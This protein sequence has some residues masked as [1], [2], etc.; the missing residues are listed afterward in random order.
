MQVLVLKSSFVLISWIH[1]LADLTESKEVV[2]C[3]EANNSIKHFLS[4]TLKECAGE[5]SQITLCI[6]CRPN[7]ATEVPTY[8]S[9]HYS[10]GRISIR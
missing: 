9:Y 2:T 7:F 10:G 5:T 8:A 6:D 1:I 3:I 4:A